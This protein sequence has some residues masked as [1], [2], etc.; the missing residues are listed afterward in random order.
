MGTLQICTPIPNQ[1]DRLVAEMDSTIMPPV[2]L[3]YLAPGTRVVFGYYHNFNRRSRAYR[4]KTGTV[5]RTVKHRPGTFFNQPEV[6]VQ[7]D[8]NK[9]PTRVEM[10]RIAIAPQDSPDGTQ[11]A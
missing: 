9:K 11:K 8:G 6:V 7:F 4:E 1:H 3:E 5:I 10:S 2:V